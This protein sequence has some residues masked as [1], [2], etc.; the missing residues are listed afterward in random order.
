MGF[1]T[2]GTTDYLKSVDTTIRNCAT[3]QAES[4]PCGFGDHFYSVCH[5]LVKEQLNIVLHRDLNV[6]N[7]LNV[8]TYLI[9]N[10]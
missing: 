8:F 6:N 3:H 4:P 7:C 1:F 5:E 10:L 2:T 9:N